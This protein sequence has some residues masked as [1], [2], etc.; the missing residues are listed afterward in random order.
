M[1]AI[2]MAIGHCFDSTTLKW[3]VTEGLLTVEARATAGLDTEPCKQ[4]LGQLGK[5]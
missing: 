5:D 1:H 4:P 3:P 2:K